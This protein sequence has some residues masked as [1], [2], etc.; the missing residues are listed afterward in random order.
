MK[1]HN[2]CPSCGKIGGVLKAYLGL[3]V[4]CRRCKTKFIAKLTSGDYPIGVPVPE[5][6]GE[7]TEHVEI[8]H[9]PAVGRVG[10]DM[11]EEVGRFQIETWLGRGGFG[12]VYLAY[13]PVLEREVALKIP[14]AKTLSNPERVARFLREAKSAARL[15]HRLS[16]RC[17]SMPTET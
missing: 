6:A 4:R 5:P 12:D 10:R 7:P 8:D 9:E 11:P 2:K 15:R 1:I 14:K 17:K 16:W 3:A 13:D